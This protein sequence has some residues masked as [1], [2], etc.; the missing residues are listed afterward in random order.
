MENAAASEKTRTSSGKVKGSLLR[1]KYIIL[2]VLACIILAC[3]QKTRINSIIGYN[4]NILLQSWLSDFAAHLGYVLFTFVNFFATFVGVVL[5]DRKGS[6]FMLSLGP[7]G[8]VVSMLCTAI[9]FR[10][11]ERQGVDSGNALQAMI[12]P[13]QSLRL[14]YD[15]TFSER[16]LAASGKDVN[17]AV[18]RPTSVVIIYDSCVDF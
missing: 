11:M 13:E 16:L 5:V 2:F 3:I 1:R 7:S 18:E 10:T 14:T 4:T 15:R 17:I 8:I 6:K 9:L 12:T